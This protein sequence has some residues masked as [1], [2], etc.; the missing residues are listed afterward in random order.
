MRLAVMADIHGNVAAFEAA[1]DHAA[2]QNV[3]RIVLA[4]D[5]I[6]GAPDSYKCWQ[7]AK[8][9]GCPILRGNHERYVAH[10]DTP[11]AHPIWKTEQFAPL[12]WT[13]AQFTGEER[14][15]IADLPLQLRL[16][17]APDILLVHA[18]ARN[19]NDTIMA[20]TPDAEIASMFEGVTEK[21][22]VR[23]HN[24]VGRVH[25]WDNRFIISNGSVGWAL[26]G[27]T[28][29]QYLVMEQR[30][31]GWKITQHSVPYDVESTLRRFE[32]TSYLEETGPI[33]YLF[34]R[35]VAT[36]SLQVNPFLRAYHRWSA[37]GV[38]SLQEAL[39]LF[40]ARGY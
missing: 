40:M 38:I 8:S 18:S 36:A 14:Q 16:E 23:A 37:Q 25:L 21:Y 28:T 6:N 17:D 3:D 19:D 31:D 7:M 30:R 34:M 33:G 27:Y 2:S 13:V 9:L 22:I 29:A 12:H 35:E 4:G 32:Q 26:D 39:A 1:L 20:H 15:E 5:I 11:Q 24:H 10:F